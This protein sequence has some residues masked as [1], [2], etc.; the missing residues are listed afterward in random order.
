MGIARWITAVNARLGGDEKKELSV[1]DLVC[2][3]LSLIEQ[4][5]AGS[6]VNPDTRWTHLKPWEIAGR[7]SQQHGERISNGTVK[8]ILR[9]EGYRKRLPS[10]Q[11]MP[12][13]GLM[14]YVSVSNTPASDT[15]SSPAISTKSFGSAFVAF[16]PNSRIFS[17]FP[18]SVSPGR[19]AFT[20]L[21]MAPS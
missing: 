16:A 19:A 21:C 13:Q 14:A 5:T 20:N 11:F 17:A 10:K 1:P 12:D 7:Y 15:P 9:A 4:E 8:R 6:P 2:R 3:L 18:I